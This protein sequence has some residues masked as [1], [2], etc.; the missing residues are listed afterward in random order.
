MENARSLFVLLRAVPSAALLRRLLERHGSAVAALAAGPV[1]WRESGLDE[2]QC[3]ALRCPDTNRLDADLAW[4]AQDAHHLID[5][6]HPDYPDLLRHAASPP[7]ALFVAGDPALLWRPQLAIVGS[8]HPTAGGCDH[9]TRFADCLGRQ[10]W[11]ITS[12]LA[13]GIDAA[14]HTAALAAGDTVAVIGTGPDL[15]YPSRH[16][17]LMQRIAAAG[18]VVSEH[19]PGTAARREHFP[20]RNRLIAGL[21]LG[22]LVV[23][24]AL[25]SGALITARLAAEAGREVFALPGSIHNPLARGCH[26]LIRQGAALVETPEEVDEA[27]RAQAQRLDAFLRPHPLRAVQAALA[28][29][30][31]S[32]TGDPA[33]RRL[34]AALGHDPLSPDQLAER[35]GLTLAELAPMLLL[36]ELDGRVQAEHGRYARRP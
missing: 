3:Q 35:T 22:T 16:Q 26:R 24:A 8:R 36:M 17:E 13:E 10:G 27:L 21:A 1:G 25:R 12:G 4:L 14:A 23:E 33:Q 20:S 34:L 2:A 7:A 31:A 18:A 15:C 19:P 30:I 9:A 32:K 28:L 6:L 29:P 5:W 11:T